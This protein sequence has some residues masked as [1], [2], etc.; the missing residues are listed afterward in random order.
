M[1]TTKDP[2]GRELS[3][4]LLQSAA[5]IDIKPI[6]WL[7]NGWLAKGKVHV[8]GGAP[9]T[10]K[11]TLAILLAASVT[12]GGFWPDGTQSPL[13]NVVIWSGED[14]PSDTLGPR[15]IAAGADL[16]R[17]FFVDLV[18]DGDGMRAFDPARDMDSL[19]AKLRRTA[20]ASLLIID[21]IVSAIAGD[22]HKNAEVRRG[23]QPLADLASSADCAVLGITHFSKGTSGRDPVERITG[24]LAFG[25]VA[26]VV[27]VAACGQNAEN[28]D[29][30]RARLF[31]RAKSNIGPDDGGFEYE[32][33]QQELL[34][35]PGVI[36]SKV[37]W[38]NTVDGSARDL[39]AEANTIT[40][41]KTGTSLGA[42][43]SFL[44][45][46]LADGPVSAKSVF[47][48]ADA[49]GH[50]RA[51]I[52]RAQKQL[53]VEKTKVGMTGGW[54]WQLPRRCSNI[55]EDTQ[56][57]SLGTFGNLEHLRSDSSVV[58]VEI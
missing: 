14:D 11:T 30:E 7:W 19:T 10:G 8:F 57:N 12:T 50:S 46:T 32:L 29:T 52:Q 47:A 3:D 45:D 13:G 27:L 34:S 4:V 36:A 1:K 38:G 28:D 31:M 48:T 17:V 6:N 25:A 23:L 21:P 55:P 9:G 43:V 2:S 54:D 5:S 49:E 24:S 51:T 26:R 44:Q 16:N 20:E 37:V 58:E 33:V 42:A 22:S 40:E 35:H 18:R 41:K 53:G 15:L 56:Q 39:L